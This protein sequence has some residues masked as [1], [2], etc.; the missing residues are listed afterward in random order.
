MIIISLDSGD[1]IKEINVGIQPSGLALSPNGR[2]LVATC[3]NT[4]YSDPVNYNDLTAGMGSIVYIDTRKWEQVP[5][6]TFAGL[7]P[8][9]VT[10]S[11][12]GKYSYVSN[13]IGNTISVINN[14]DFVSK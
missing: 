8:S 14:P 10:I 12:N 6:A 3:Y 13:Y 5:Y 7:A 1:I 9:N 11:R 2:Y 4:L